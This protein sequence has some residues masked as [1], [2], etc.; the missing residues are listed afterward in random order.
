MLYERRLQRLEAHEAIRHLKARYGALADAKYTQDY[1]RQPSETLRDIA[2]QQA[3]C[4]TEDASWHAGD[5]FGGVIQGQTEL[6]DW[7]CR[8]PWLWAMHFYS[9]PI[10]ELVDDVNATAQWRLF[11]L[12]LKNKKEEVVL[13]SAVTEESYCKTE[14]GDWLHHSVRFKELQLLSLKEDVAKIASALI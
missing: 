4:F 7:F 11:Q 13:L 8:A 5:E 12:A 9:S 6:Y 14:D 10:I 1:Q 2:W 3:L